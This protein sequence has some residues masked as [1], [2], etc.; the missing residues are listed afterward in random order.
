M[1]YNYV[2]FTIEKLVFYV[3][4]KAFWYTKIFHYKKVVFSFNNKK[5]KNLALEIFKIFGK[6]IRYENELND[7][8][9]SSKKCAI[10]IFLLKIYI[11]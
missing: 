2:Y 10:K 8:Q 7:I 4:I 11:S 3:S 6:I 9:M 1:F 5:E